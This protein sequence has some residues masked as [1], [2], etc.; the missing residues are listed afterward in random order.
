MHR[1]G[2]FLVRELSAPEE[3]TELGGEHGHYTDTLHQNAAMAF[4]AIAANSLFS[5]GRMV[6][7]VRFERTTFRV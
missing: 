6:G 7:T 1:E 5:V 4:E 3:S 2:I